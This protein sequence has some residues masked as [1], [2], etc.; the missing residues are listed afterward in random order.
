MTCH[1]T[2]QLRGEALCSLEVPLTFTVLELKHA[3]STETGL[4]PRRLRFLLH[5]SALDDS[6]TLASYSLP[7]SATLSLAFL[8]RPAA[9]PDSLRF[10]I[11][12]PS[13]YVRALQSDPSAVQALAQNPA[14]AHLLSDSDHLREQF[15]LLAGDRHG[16][17]TAKWLP[18]RK[19][20]G[21]HLSGRS[22]VGQK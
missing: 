7:A 17:R 16:A 3:V 8:P 19:Q 20:R 1:L 13:A 11:E 5:S 18:S 14:V 22:E 2:I 4:D 21:L 10:V 9:L 12:D 15:S 6:R